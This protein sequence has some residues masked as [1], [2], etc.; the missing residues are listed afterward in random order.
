MNA[1]ARHAT[2]LGAL[3]CFS[4]STA[5]AETIY[6][7]VSGRISF[8]VRTNVPF[9]RVAGSSSALR[10]RGEGSVAGTSARVQNLR[11]EIDPTSFAT[12]NRLRDRHMIEQV[13]T[14]P[15]G[16]VPPVGLRAA[17]FQV[18]L[19]PGTATWAG[20]LRAEVTLRGV[21]RPVTFQATAT[22]RGDGALV[23]AEALLKTPD[24]GVKPISHAGVTVR[25]EVRVT[26]EDLLVQ[27]SSR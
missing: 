23:R 16:S 6:Q 21:T 10:G 11:F 9:I 18:R 1:F 17:S 25:E 7:A 22:R 20:E 4:C 3:L 19:K 8:A 13:F 12:G 26:V 27:P 24:F 15:D 5:G 14:A 2:V